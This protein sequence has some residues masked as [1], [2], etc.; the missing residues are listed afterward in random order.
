MK[1]SVDGKLLR[2]GIQGRGCLL[3]WSN[4]ILAKGRPRTDTSKVGDCLWTDLAGFL[5]RLGYVGLPRKAKVRALWE[6]GSGL[7]EA[8]KS[9]IKGRVFV[10]HP[11]VQGQRVHSSFERCKFVSCSV[12]LRSCRTSWT[13]CWPH[14][15]EGVCWIVWTVRHLNERVHDL[16]WWWVFW[17]FYHIVVWLQLVRLL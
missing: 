17:S 10:A 5:R 4:R 14:A 12:T 11:L 6:E 8:S 16:L 13:I 9:L 15:V 3:N 7:R 1:A 2:G